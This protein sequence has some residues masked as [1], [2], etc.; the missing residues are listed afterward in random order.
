MAKFTVEL[1]YT[2]L[3]CATVV[4]EAADFASACAKA[5]EDPPYDDFEDN[6]EATGEL[7]VNQIAEGEVDLCEEPNAIANVP[8]GYAEEADR[9]RADRNRLHSALELLAKA[10]EML[11]FPDGLTVELDP[12]SPLAVAR[13]A[14]TG[15]TDA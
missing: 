9:L 2:M 5:M 3:S 10:Y 8:I 13:R 6:S 15:M 12:S 4:V 1:A 14:L 7:F 11:R